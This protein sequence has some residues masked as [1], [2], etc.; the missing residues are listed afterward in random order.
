[1]IFSGCG[2]T[3]YVEYVFID[4]F[5][6]DYMLMKATLVTAGITVIKRRLFVCAFLGAAFALLYPLLQINTYLLTIIKILFGFV[7]IT[8]AVPKISF[9]KLKV[10][11]AL[12]LLYTFLLGGAIAGI[13]FIIDLNYSTEFFMS[14]IV[15]VAYVVI[16]TVISAIKFISHKKRTDCFVAKVIIEKNGI[17]VDAEGFF[18]TGNGVYNETTPVIFC[19]KKIAERFLTN[20]Y[21]MKEVKKIK[22]KT[23]CEESEKLF[24]KVDRITIYNKDVKN[25]FYNVG[26]AV[27]EKNFLSDYDLIL[28]PAFMEA[29]NEQ[30][31][32]KT[33]KTS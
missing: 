18:D 31:D 27:L 21:T 20:V 6:I 29:D 11:F 22:I 19:S 28:H 15:V 1:M 32:F 13:S 3:V 12:F 33:Q 9:K 23:V 10:C 8:V 2:M 24:F 14:V 4:N 16:K 17:V 30:I 26:L 7:L 5:I 25:T